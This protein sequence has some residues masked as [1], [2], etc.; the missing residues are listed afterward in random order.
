MQANTEQ[1]KALAEQLQ[2]MT[3]SYKASLIS[4][5][6]DL[7]TQISKDMKASYGLIETYTRN[8]ADVTGSNQVES[9]ERLE[10]IATIMQSVVESSSDIAGL[11]HD[12]TVS[13]SNMK[14]ALTGTNEGSLGRF[15]LNMN[16]NV[17]DQ[18]KK[19]ETSLAAQGSLGALMQE[20][21]AELLKRF[22]ALE[23]LSESSIHEMRQLPKEIGRD[24][25]RREASES[26]LLPV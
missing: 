25:A 24:L 4:I 19:L 23:K 15:L 7:K 26:S 14:E 22:R 20:L 8:V 13:M 5:T 3:E 16:E 17:I 18:L 1:S 6:T 12:N 11:L 21:N 10:A 2:A 9:L